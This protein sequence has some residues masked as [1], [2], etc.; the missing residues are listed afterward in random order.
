MARDRQVDVQ[1][2]DQRAAQTFGR[3]IGCPEKLPDR[4]QRFDAKVA[5]GK[6]AS[7]FVFLILVV[8]VFDHI[9]V[10]PQSKLSAF[11]ESVMIFFPVDDFSRRPFAVDLLVDFRRG[12][13]RT[14]IFASFAG[15]TIF[16]RFCRPCHG[17]VCVQVKFE[18]S[19]PRAVAALFR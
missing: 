2:L 15:L 9:V 1:Q 8:P 18:F 19:R 11:D 6:R 13:F 16:N 3:P 12:F 5:V 17:L 4:Q 10:D 14:F 7:E